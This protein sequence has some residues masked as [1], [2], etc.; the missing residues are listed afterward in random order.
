MIGS[1]ER[2]ASIPEVKFD[3]SSGKIAVFCNVVA[4]S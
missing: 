1:I 2:G 3:V 4:Q